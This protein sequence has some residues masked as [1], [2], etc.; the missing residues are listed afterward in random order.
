[1]LACMK[2]ETPYGWIDLY[3]WRCSDFA[4]SRTAVDPEIDEPGE[5]DERRKEPWEDKKAR[6]H[7]FAKGATLTQPLSPVRY[8]NATVTRKTVDDTQMC[9][10]Y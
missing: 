2:N 9:N 7:L 8:F 1:M 6:E 3:Y 10:D 5:T 4:I